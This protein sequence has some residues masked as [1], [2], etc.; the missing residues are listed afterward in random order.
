VLEDR[1]VLEELARLRVL[2][3]KI[4]LT[5]TGPRQGETV[6]RALGVERLFDCVQATWNLLEPSAERP[7]I[8]GQMA[9][10]V[11]VP[12][13]HLA[14]TQAT[15][16]LVRPHLCLRPRRPSAHKSAGCCDT[17]LGGR[18][19]A[20]QRSNT[21]GLPKKEQKGFDKGK[22]QNGVLEPLREADLIE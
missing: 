21:G 16:D 11:E 17:L 13:E 19:Q 3:W 15:V 22:L 1:A 20:A 9:N 6:R 5:V 7:N 8:L 18:P 12:E 14:G 4:G 10:F 2:G